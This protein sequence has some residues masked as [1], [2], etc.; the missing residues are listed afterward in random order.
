MSATS[1]TLWSID[2]LGVQV[3]LMLS[4]NQ[5]DSPSGRVREVPDLRTIRYYTTLGLIDRP[6]EMRGRTSLYGRR[7][8]AQIVAIKRLQAKGLTLT[9]IQQR[10]LGLSDAKLE[11]LAELAA[12]EGSH[13]TTS[14]SDTEPRRNEAFWAASPEPAAAPLETEATT[15]DANFVWQGVSME[16]GVVLLFEPHRSLDDDDIR[17]APR[18]GGASAQSHAHAPAAGRTAAPRKGNSMN[19]SL[20][21]MTE[22]EMRGARRRRDRSRNA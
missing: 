13:A 15:P 2:E 14:S 19:D 17:G 10:L 20:T 11:Q 1:A 9:E 21:I 16:E 18:G 12:S 4:A 6:A 3:S 5:P 8:L 7:H 22:E